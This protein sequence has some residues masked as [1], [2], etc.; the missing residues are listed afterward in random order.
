MTSGKDGDVVDQLSS[1]CEVQTKLSL[2]PQPQQ[3]AP[4]SLRLRGSCQYQNRVLHTNILLTPL[5]YRDMSSW[6]SDIASSHK[7]QLA[8]TAAASVGLTVSA[9]LG[10]QQARR[11][12][13]V[14]DLKHSIPD[15]DSK[16]DIK[17]VCSS[18]FFQIDSTVK[19]TLGFRSIHLAEHLPL[20]LQEATKKM[21]EV[22][23][24]P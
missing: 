7:L 8:V 19:L 4:Q 10:L 13:N 9:V 18:K 12:Y 22:Q 14:N 24:L 6:M 2:F 23:H 1:S 16:H 15:L 5:W 21:R 20:Q 3:A 11:W 17:R